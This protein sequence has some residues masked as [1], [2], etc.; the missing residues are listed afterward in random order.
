MALSN[1]PRSFTTPFTHALFELTNETDSMWIFKL[2][3]ALYFEVDLEKEIMVRKADRMIHAQNLTWAASNGQKR[4]ESWFRLDSSKAHIAALE[5]SKDIEHDSVFNTKK[6][7]DMVR[8]G[9][10]QE[11]GVWIHPEL[12]SPLAGWISPDFGALAWS[13]VTRIMAGDITMM[14]VVRDAHDAVHGT[15]TTV[16]I[17]TEP[18]NGRKRPDYVAPVRAVDPSLR[19]RAKDT[20]HRLA[21]FVSSNL[22]KERVAPVMAFLGA[23]TCEAATGMDAG[24]LK[25]LNGIRHGSARDAMEDAQL[26]NSWFYMFNVMERTKNPGEEKDLR[27]VAEDVLKDM[28]PFVKPPEGP[29]PVELVNKNKQEMRDDLL[30]TRPLNLERFSRSGPKRIKT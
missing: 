22:P 20:Q 7:F 12:V 29:A 1:A 25:Q 5:R 13:W 14:Q 4:F 23:K 26:A 17:R 2:K 3:P 16:L 24:S 27:N 9:P 30:L 28:A 11:R 8:T 10:V 15:A 18:G 19:I 21:D 6:A